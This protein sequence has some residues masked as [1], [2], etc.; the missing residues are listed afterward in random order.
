[1]WGGWYNPT[2]GCS[3]QIEMLCYTEAVIQCVLQQ[4][5]K[6][7]LVWG[8]SHDKHEVYHMISM[9]CI[10]RFSVSC[11]M[12]HVM[13]RDRFEVARLKRVL[14]ALT[15]TYKC[16]LTAWLR[17]KFYC[18]ISI[19]NTIE[20][21]WCSKGKKLTSGGVSTS[22]FSLDIWHF[23][24]KRCTTTLQ[25]QLHVIMDAKQPLL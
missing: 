23:V 12:Y 4:I 16:G 1:M 22:M 7:K 9:R 13:T 24:V 20:P 10:T 14:R 11:I 19:K 8:V 15:W 18:I 3:L 17:R 25:R 6:N 2:Q 21:F 5:S